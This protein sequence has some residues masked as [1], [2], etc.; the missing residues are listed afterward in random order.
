MNYYITLAYSLSP[1]CQLKKSRQR[2]SPSPHVLIA[3]LPPVGVLYY[4][5][6][7]VLPHRTFI[8]FIS[9]NDS[10]LAGVSSIQRAHVRV[11]V[12]YVNP[13]HNKCNQH[14]RSA[15]DILAY[16]LQKIK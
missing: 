10:Q 12:T 11:Y 9:T 6:I 4:T 7:L 13:T 16:N 8:I 2:Q 5:Q 1:S 3:T 14:S 15:R